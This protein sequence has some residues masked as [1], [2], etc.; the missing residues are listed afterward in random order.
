LTQ[1]S[2]ATVYWMQHG[3]TVAANAHAP[4]RARGVEGSSEASD[5]PF[6]KSS[7]FSKILAAIVVEGEMSVAVRLASYSRPSAD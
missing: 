1:G 6:S 5:T 4:A 3:A 2:L 7:L